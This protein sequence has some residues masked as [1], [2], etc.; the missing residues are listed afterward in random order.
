M[1]ELARWLGEQ[2]DTDEGE[3]RR[4]YLKAEPPPDYDGWD[5]STVAG[6]PPVVAARVLREIDAKRRVIATYIKAVE[7]M[8]ELASLCERLKAEGKDTFMP[9][10]DRATAIHRRD[11]LH[12]TLQVLSLP[13]ADR[14]G[15][16]EEWRP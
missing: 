5:K 10:M 13:Y 1:G 2:L 7:R 6:L 12:E 11:V 15:Y 14:P 16:R 9:E 3:A 4:G 8:E